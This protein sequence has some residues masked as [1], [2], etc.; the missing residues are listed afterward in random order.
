[1]IDGSGW[2]RFNTW[3]HSAT[4][5]DLYTRRCRR[6][7]APMVSHL[8]AARLLA[9]HVA[10]G[11]SLL[12]AGCG[13]G[14]FV[15]ALRDQQVPAEYYGCDAAPPLI[16]IGREVLPGHGLPVERLLDLRIED[17]NATV[18]HVVCINVLSNLDNYHRPLER[19]L[20]S[21][22]KTVLIR[23]SIAERASYSYVDDRYLDPGVSLKVYVNTYARADVQAFVESYGFQVTFEIDDYTKGEPQMVI[24][25]PHRWTFLKATRLEGRN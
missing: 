15:H 6:E 20:L 11:D 25:H 9:P 12:D 1:M 19:L 5:R 22:R 16:A 8:Q 17:L 23:E 24:G 18:D 7:V 2:S 3:E 10:A 14:Y 4:V 13:S 21:A